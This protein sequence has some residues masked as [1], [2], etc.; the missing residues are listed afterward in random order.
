MIRSVLYLFVLPTIF[1]IS[2]CGKKEG[3]SG[4]LEAKDQISYNFHVRPILSDNCFACHGPDANTRE[5]GLRLDVEEAAYAALKENPDAHA[6][7]PGDPDNSEAFRRIISDDPNE[8]MPPPESHLTLSEEEVSIIRKWVSQGAVYEDH[9]AFVPPAKTELPDIKDDSWPLNEIDYFIM[10]KM[11]EVGL[12]PNEPAS[13]M[14]LLKRLSLDLNGLPPTLEMMDQ[15]RKDDGPDA[16]E[17]IVDQ[18][19]AQPSF[20]EKLAVLW[21]DVSRYSDSYGYQDDN[22][23]TQ[24]PYRDWVIHAFNTDLPYDKFITWQLAGDMLPDANKEQILATAFNRNHK[25]TE[26]GGVIDEEYRVEYILDKT[27]TFSKAIL[28]MTVECAQCH[29]HKYD[30]IS[31][32][33]YFQMYSFFN[34]TPEKGYEGDVSQSKPA[35][36]PIMYIEN[37]DIEN[38]L[39]FV[40]A[41]DTSR[42][43]V[44]VMEELDTL[45]PTYILDRGLYDARTVEVGPDTPPSIMAFDESLPKNRLGLAQWTVSRDNPLTARVFVNLIWQEIFGSGLVKTAGDFGMQ[46]DMPS[47]PELL[48]WLAVEFMESNW[49]IKRLIKLIVSSSTY[50]QSAMVKMDKLE[51]DPDNIYLSSAPRLRLNA[52]NIRDLVLASSELLVKEI[53]GPSVKPYQPAGFWEASTSGRGE[54]AV[55]RQD[56]GEDLFR[57]GLYTFI[58]LTS[59]PPTQIG[60][61]SCRERV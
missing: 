51:K 4:G 52:E 38:I 25:Y 49:D 54:L 20:G 24:W 43:M 40:N 22:V 34:N 39:S 32:E 42:I 1:L 28:G 55:Y 35:K 16:Y 18:L 36:T 2:S 61:A 59:P 31:Q 3:A 53:G 50:Q 46:G 13:K 8:K 56:K 6:I 10:D 17:K 58:K 5:A 33:N 45:R 11:S 37:E 9:W 14:H 7:V 30:P 60:R 26:E 47:H 21:M 57:R 19:L 15:F 27:N 23:R 44:S 29:D 48:D 12:S 41:P